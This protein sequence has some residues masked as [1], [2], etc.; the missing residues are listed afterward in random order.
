MKRI[1]MAKKNKN[2]QKKRTRASR[3]QARASTALDKPAADYAALLA[4]PCNAPLVHP[5][6]AGGD[7][8]FLFRAENFFTFGNTTGVTSGVIHWAPGYVN[9][10][11]TELVG[12]T[13][14]TSATSG[15]VQTFAESPGRGFLGTNARG[16]RCVAACVKISFPGAES[17]RSGRIHYG[18]TNAGL[19]DVGDTITAD[20]VGQTLQNYSRTPTDTIEVVWKPGAGDTEFND[21]SAAASATMR[22]RKQAI[23][24]AWAGLPAAVGLTFHFTAV[25]EWTPSYGLGVAHNSL[26]KNRSRNTLDNV[27]DTLID[28]G[29]TFVRDM[30]AAAMGPMSGAALGMMQR[31]FGLMPA[32]GRQRTLTY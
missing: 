17:A 26:G 27:V 10:T 18:H 19:M 25:Y 2:G 21:P 8:G 31:A 6:Y 3:R 22:D 9:S 15:V 14:A 12:Q 32:G 23:T 13:F 28:R 7:S 11:N 4:D 1:Q 29:F 20:A 5:V 24:V 16:A 30:G